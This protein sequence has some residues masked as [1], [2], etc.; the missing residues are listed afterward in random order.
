MNLPP[1]KRISAATMFRIYVDAET[2][3]PAPTSSSIR[4]LMAEELLRR[5]YPDGP[6]IVVVC[7][8]PVAHEKWSHLVRGVPILFIQVHL[9]EPD[10]EYRDDD[11]PTVRYLGWRRADDPPKTLRE[12]VPS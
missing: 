4:R 6:C 1:W 8:D 11:P 3:K 10:S 12:G 2:M 9:P 5:V 7:T